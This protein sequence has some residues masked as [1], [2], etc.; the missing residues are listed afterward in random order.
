M[1]IIREALR[2]VMEDYR[3]IWFHVRH[4]TRRVP[5]RVYYV[6]LIYLAVWS[7]ILVHLRYQ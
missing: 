7:L 4:P 6:L 2:G 3:L 5:W 1:R